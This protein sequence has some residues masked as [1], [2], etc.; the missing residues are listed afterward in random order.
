M[1]KKLLC[2]AIVCLF[3]FKSFAQTNDYSEFW[4]HLLANERAEAGKIISKNKS[5]SIEWL[6]INELYRNEIGKIKRNDKF[7]KPFLAKADFENYL[8]AFWNRSFFFDDYLSEGFNINTYETLDAVS[9]LNIKNIDLKD[10]ILYLEA[11]RQR[12]H[13]NWDDFNRLNAEINAIKE[14]QYCGSFENLNKSGLDK[15]YEP[16]TTSANDV[17]FD[18]KSNGIVRWYNGNNTKEAYQF[19]SNHNEYG[20]SV[21]YAQTF[22][23]SSIDQRVIIRIG[24]GS[25]FKL[26]LNDVEIYK[27]EKDV[28]TD[29]NGFEVVVNLPKGNNRLLVKSAESNSNSYFMVAVF[30]ENKKPLKN[31]SISKNPTSYNTSSFSALNPVEKQNDVERYF[32]SKIAEQPDN[33]L[34]SYALYSTYL[35]NSKYNEA[36]DVIMPF[37]KEFPKSSML[38]SALMTTYNL[39]NDYTSSNEINENIERDDPDYYLPIVNKVTEYDELSRLTM[40]EFEEYIEKLKKAFDSEMIKGAADFLYFARKEDLNGIKKTLEHLNTLAEDYD[41]TN[42]KLRYAPLFDQLFQD[43]N[44]TIKALEEIAKEKFSLSAENQLINYYDKKNEKNKVLKLI[45]KHYDELGNQNS[46]LKRI[47]NRYVEY[48]MFDKALPYTEKMLKNYPYSFTTMELRGDILKQMGKTEE[49]LVYYEKALAHNSGDSGLRKKINDVSKKSNLINELVLEEAYDYITENRNKITTNNYGFNIL[50]DEGNIEIFE[51]GGF[52]YR[53]VYIY[54]VTSNNGIESFKEYNLGLGGSYKFLKSELVKPD[55]SIV[56]AARSG[57]NLVFNDISIGDVVYIDYEGVVTTT[58]RFYKDI[59]DKMQFDSFHPMV[60]TSMD[61]LVPN[62]SQLNYKYMNGSLEPKITKKKDHVLYQWELKNAKTLE[63]AEDYMP[64][65]VD[66]LG[67][68]HFN[69]IKSWNDIAVWYSDLVRTRIEI[70]SKVEIEFKKLFPEGHEGLSENERAK[71]IYNYITSNFNYSYVSFKQSGFI[72]QK[73]AKTINTSLGD[74]KDFSTLFVTL[75]KMAN[76]NSNLVLVLTSD[77]GRNNLVLPSTDFNHCIVKVMIDGKPQFLELT[78]KYLPYKA[79]PTSLRGATALEIPFDAEK[80]NETF[81]LIHLDN[82]NRIK[83][84]VN[85]HINIDLS[86]D[87]MNLQ[88]ATEVIGHNTAYYKEVFSEPNQEVIKKSMTED[89]SSKLVDD[90]TLNTITNYKENNDLASITYD[91]DITLN[92]KMSSIGSIKILQLPIVTHPYENS[93]IQLEERK[94]PINYIQYETV[95]TYYTEYIIEIEDGETFVEIPE[96]KQFSFKDHK[97]SITYKNEKPNKLNVVIKATTPY[98][99]VMPEDYIAY[100]TYVKGILD[101]ELEYIGFK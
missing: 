38:R 55:G 68:L 80:T 59:S 101:A 86:K 23:N 21:N 31:I 6:I 71:I 46:Y 48:Q 88:I 20:S 15:F 75:A 19:Y 97:Y 56:P 9:K 78:S 76:L 27:Y 3:A 17:D 36:R 98:D 29:L 57:S 64:N 25:A 65:S 94:Y 13:N 53:Y 24:S 67:Y 90:F 12:H 50:L 52:K 77:Y 33:F 95:D 7:L 39:E 62:S 66:E 83:S 85:N 14:W 73:P 44:R 82:I 96:S 10:A 30:D 22:I 42:F 47:V 40:D 8:F 49:A 100:K 99:D 51:E 32:K 93:I 16:E 74:C 72:P 61:I 18:A 69:T 26:F 37:Y 34:Y 43:Q 58:G 28:S 87:H 54:E 2:I 92:K 41:N 4:N 60:F 11:I 89:Y 35:R 84:K 91:A 45:D 81:D 1:N 79:L 5:A 63:F 70:N